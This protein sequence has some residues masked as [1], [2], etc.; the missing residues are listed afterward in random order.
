M[1]NEKTKTKIKKN[2]GRKRFAKLFKGGEGGRNDAISVVKEK[3]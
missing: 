1:K 3:I 2:E